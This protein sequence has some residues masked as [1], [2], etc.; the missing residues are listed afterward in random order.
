M[1]FMVDSVFQKS[2]KLQ[3]EEHQKEIEDLI[4]S[5]KDRINEGLKSKLRKSLSITK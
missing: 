3:D 1:N 2:K 4:S 5:I